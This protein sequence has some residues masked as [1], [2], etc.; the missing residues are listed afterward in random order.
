MM[1]G[2]D[3]VDVPLCV[4]Y[5]ETDQMGRAYYANYFVWF[6]VARTSF[7]KARGFSYAELERETRTF[8]PVIETVC[9][10]HRSLSY[11]D[12][13]VVRTRVTEFRS[14]AVTFDYQVLDGQGRLV[15]SG[16]TRHLFTGDDGRPKA[17]PEAY[18]RFLKPGTF[19][20]PVTEPPATEV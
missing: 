20:G 6:E 16:F 19:G 14:R 2:C 7:C 5:A 12:G 8:L 13:F 3:Y 4:R 18:R 15:A 17:L 1:H 10:Y 9:R 11:D